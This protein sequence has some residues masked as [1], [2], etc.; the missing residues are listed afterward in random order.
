MEENKQLFIM[1]GFDP[2]TEQRLKDWETRLERCGRPGQQT[3]NIPHHITLGMYPPAMEEQVKE[4]VLQ[5]ASET[6]PF[7][8]SFQH[9][10]IFGGGRVLFAAPCVDRALLNL[11]ERF[12]SGTGW[13]AHAT[14]LIDEPEN[15]L[16]A[17][18]PAVGMFEEFE[19]RIESIFVHE[20]FPSRFVLSLPLKGK[21]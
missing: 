19:G 18:A 12:G 14:L 11:K 13:T 5:A 15:I 10:G 7:P 17:V 4:M 1:A 2:E 8:V 21:P 6:A 20:F 16:S 9:L 3:K